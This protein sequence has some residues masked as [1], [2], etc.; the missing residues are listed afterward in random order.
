MPMKPRPSASPRSSGRSTPW[1]MTSH[2][3][4]GSRGM[5]AT[6][7]K[8]LPRPAGQHAE[9]AVRRRAARRPRRRSARRPTAS[10]PPRR[11]RPRRAPGR[12]RACRSRVRSVWKATPSSASRASTAGQRRRGPAAP[13]VRVDDERSAAAHRSGEH[14]VGQPV[15]ERRGDAG[16]GLGGAWTPRRR[17]PG[18]AR[19]A[20]SMPAARAAPTSASSRSPTASARPGPRRSSAVRKSSASGLPTLRARHAGRGLDRGDDRAGPRPRAVGH[21][22][23]ARRGRR[24]AARRP[25]GPPAPRRAARRSAGRRARRRRRRRR[26]RGSSAPTDRAGR[27]PAT[28]RWIAARADDDRRPPRRLRAGEANGARPTVTTSSREAWKPRRHSLRTWSSS[29]WRPSLVTK[30]RPL[31]A[32][33]SAATASGARGVGSSPTQRQP[34]RSSSTWS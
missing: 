23:G 3:A 22:E 14:Q 20:P 12:G 30:A 1:A 26:G 27:P 15:G 11:P 29:A 6:R 10:P 5:P 13:G 18:A 19:C 8:S 2:A 4:T 7:A 24:T 32:A 25:R 16:A 34:S 9:H 31:P 33:R 21:R 28:W 17:A